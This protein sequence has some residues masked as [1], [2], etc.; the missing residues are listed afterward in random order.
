M[1]I[2]KTG[3]NGLIAAVATAFL[4]AGACAAAA[5]DG[6]KS[7]GKERELARR[8]L[9][10]QQENSNLTG[11]LKAL[12]EKS[13]QMTQSN[14]HAT[15]DLAA[16]KKENE[17]LRTELAAK[18]ELATK[19]EG[20]LNDLKQKFGEISNQLAQRD[21]QKRQ[22]E[23]TAALQ[24]QALG[25]QSQLIETC[26]TGNA[27]LYKLSLELLQKLKSEGERDA[28]PMIGLRTVESF[29]E[30]QGYRD[31]LDKLKVDALPAS[32]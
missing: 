9:R 12:G 28:E 10:L 14:N 32:R 20:E 21:L 31:K 4:L 22:I 6:K 26:R 29:D 27:G 1:D 5:E 7:A 15:R 17:Q 30:Y 23:E 2:R 25:R 19:V 8:V 16:S 24:V 11:Q 18:A 3:M 13:E